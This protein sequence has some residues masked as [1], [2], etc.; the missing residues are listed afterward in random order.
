MSEQDNPAP[1]DLPPRPDRFVDDGVGLVLERPDGTR[2]TF[3]SE[4][5]RVVLSG[6]A[7][8]SEG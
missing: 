6:P 8:T 3:D 4:G 1:D 5:N 7:T 2:I